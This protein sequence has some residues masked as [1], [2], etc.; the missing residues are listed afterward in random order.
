M[1]V[2]LVYDRV[3]KFGGAE[4]VLLA[5]KKLYPDAPLYTLVYNKPTAPWAKGLGSFQLSLIK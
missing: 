2:A 4:R 3:N 1:K 5:L